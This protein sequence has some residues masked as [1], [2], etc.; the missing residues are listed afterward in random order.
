MSQSQDFQEALENLV[1]LKKMF[2]LLTTNRENSLETIGQQKS[3]VIK[4]IKYWSR[5]IK[6]KVDQSET[7]T[8]QE[9]EQ[10]CKEGTIISDQVVEC[11]SA[12][13]AIETSQR[14]LI[15]SGKLEDLNKVF[16]ILSKVSQQLWKYIQKYDRI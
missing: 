3:D 2:V 8:K 6:G 10:I 7:A 13:A 1:I 5:V 12:I 15:E 11:K 4:T 9:L 14:M 16:V